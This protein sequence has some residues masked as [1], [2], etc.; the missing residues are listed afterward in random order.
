MTISSDNNDSHEFYNIPLMGQVR[1]ETDF[2]TRGDYSIGEL[3]NNIRN[4]DAQTISLK[5][6]D[7][8]LSAA[9]ILYGDF[10]TVTLDA[11]L[12]NNDIAA[13]RLGPRIYI[14]KIFF[15]RNLIRLDTAG[16]KSSPLIV[17]N[18]TPG[19]EIIGKVTSVIR[20]L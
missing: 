18:G 17:E 1:V 10:L 6:M 20:E 13:V 19:F 3:V 9:G 16:T 5:A 8:G 11:T 7:D 4:S 14:R 15:E 12:H 2:N